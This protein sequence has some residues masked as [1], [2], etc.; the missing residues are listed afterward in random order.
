MTA[1]H[2]K[3]LEQINAVDEWKR[4][5][6]SHGNKGTASVNEWV[7]G[8]FVSLAQGS[9]GS[10]SKDVKRGNVETYL[11]GWSLPSYPY[12]VLTSRTSLWARSQGSPGRSDK[13]SSADYSGIRVGA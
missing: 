11:S 9:P 13:A 12:E 6:A 10:Q 5:L 2:D 1:L 8:W 3:N 4:E 7:D